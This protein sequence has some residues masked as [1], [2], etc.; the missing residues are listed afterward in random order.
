MLGYGDPADSVGPTYS[1]LIYA[2]ARVIS[3]AAP[4]ITSIVRSV[5]NIEITF[6]PNSADVPPQFVL[7]QSAGSVTGAYSDTTSTITA[8]DAGAFKSVKPLGASATFSRIRRM[9]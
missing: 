4:V 7:Q 1:S 2:N 5:G 8:P 6:T 9:H 3:L